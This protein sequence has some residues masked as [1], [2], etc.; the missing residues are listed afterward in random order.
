[1]EILLGYL[2]LGLLAGLLAGLL[3]VGGGLVIVPALLF[4]FRYQGF[5]EA[6]CMHLAVGSSLASVVFTS[7]SSGLAHHRRG[8]V[9]IR[10][11]MLLTPGILVGAVLGAWLAD[12]VTA[13]LLQWIFGGFEILVAA[14]LAW[15][16]RPAAHRE[17]PAQPAL[18]GIGS[19]IGGLSALLGIG[20]GTLTVPFLVW[21]NV[22]MHRA[23]GTS[24]VCGLPIAL[25]GALGF[26]AT[27]WAVVGLPPGSSGYLY[28]P[29]I[30]TV[31][32]ASA[33]SAP[34]GARWAHAL[35]VATLKRVFAGV[36][37]L[38]GVRMLA[39]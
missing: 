11:V 18:I 3:G 27:G 14:Q 7:V 1:M 31:V 4:L 8:A 28:W 2:S 24:A 16:Y 12:R 33:L 30:A 15:G 25:A 21:C 38:I 29:A 39:S 26:A 13:R 22:A 20:G 10:T 9:C 36:L 35:P 23:V 19:V 17:L 34:L 37:L 32:A 5:P 6:L